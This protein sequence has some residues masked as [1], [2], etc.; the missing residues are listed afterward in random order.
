MSIYSCWVTCVHHL[1][2]DFQ[3][4]RA[5]LRM[6]VSIHASVFLYKCMQVLMCVCVC[7]CIDASLELNVYACIDT[8]HRP[9]FR[10]YIHILMNL[11]PFE[12][13]HA[14]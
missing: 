10:T 13:I 9:S 3:Y 4:M 5:R 1:L 6:S 2:C 12:N 7:V 11:R 8:R 14:L